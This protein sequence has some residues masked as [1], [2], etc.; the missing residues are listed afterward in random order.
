MI[1]RDRNTVVWQHPRVVT[2]QM[3]AWCFPEWGSGG[4]AMTR[5]LG[6]SVQISVLPSE[7]SQYTAELARCRLGQLLRPGPGA[8][9]QGTN[10][11]LF[12]AAPATGA[13]SR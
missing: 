12:P 9:L 1:R 8:L 6:I 5:L 2:G 11:Q 10:S 7:H 13:H 4:G 3:Y